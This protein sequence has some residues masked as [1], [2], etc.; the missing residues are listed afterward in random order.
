MMIAEMTAPSRPAVMASCNPAK[1]ATMAM[2]V[3]MVMAAQERANALVSV[4]TEFITVTL[5]TAMTAMILT[6]MRA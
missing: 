2:K 5:R 6:S 3:M 4:E 1:T